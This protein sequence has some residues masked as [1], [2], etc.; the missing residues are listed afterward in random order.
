MTSCAGWCLLA[1]LASGV[2]AADWPTYQRDQG[3]SG[4]TPERLTLPLTEHWTYRAVQP[5]RPAWPAPA[6]RDIWHE[7]RELKPL[8]TYDRAFHTVVVGDSVFFASSGD[9]A[10]R[11]L[12]VAT[13]LERWTFFT[14]GPVRLAPVVA[15]GKAFVGSDDGAIYALAAADGALVWK[16]PVGPPTRRVA[17]NGRLISARPV[18]T[19]LVVEGDRL[20]GFAGLFP[21]EGVY[22]CV[23]GADDGRVWAE[24]SIAALSPQ[25]YLLASRDR[26]YVPTGRTT[27]A[28]FDKE[29]GKYLSSFGGTGG[30][31]ALLVDDLIYTRADREGNVGLSDAASRERIATFDGL[32]ILVAGGTAYLHTRSELAALDRVR[33]TA[34][35]RQHSAVSQRL[36]GIEEQLKG[37]PAADTR[38][39][40]EE[41]RAEAK[42]EARRLQEAMAACFTWRAPCDAPYH[43]ILA[44]D[45]LY[46]GGE[47]CVRAY[48]RADGKLRWTGRVSG[49]AYGLSVAQGR[50]FVSTDQGTI[51]C[52]GQGAPAGSSNEVSASTTAAAGAF[53][54]DDQA[55]GFAAAAARIAAQTGVRQ[56]Y[57]LV[58]GNGT[59]WLA[60][61][62]ARRTDLHIVGLEDNPRQV[63]AARSALSAAGLYGS[64][65]VVHEGSV[66]RPPYGA[67][68]FNLIVSERA[69]RT[70]AVPAPAEEVF[71][72]LR[73]EGGVA[74][75]GQ[76]D[77]FS[78]PGSPARFDSWWEAAQLT[79]T[80]VVQRA[81]R[82]LQVRRGPVPGGGEWTQLY[83]NPS[84]TASN[85]DRVQGPLAVQW[86]GEPGPRRIVDRHHRP[87][88]SLVKAGRLFVPGDDI[89]F[90]VDAYN[91][92]PLW[93]LEIPK[94]RRVGALKDSGQML[95]TDR[96][97]HV[98]TQ[99]ECWLV[100]VER[101]KRSGTLK[102]PQPIAGQSHDWGYLNQWNDRVYGTGQ[103][104]GASFT[105]LHKDTINTLEGDFRPVIV[106]RYVFSLGYDGHPHWLYR[107]GALMNNA[108]AIGDGRIYLLESRAPAV[109]ND[110]DGRVG[111]REF[112]AGE[113]YLVAL[114][115][116]R[117]GNVYERPV[118][119]PFEHI[120]FLN[121]A[122]N[123]VLIS[124]SFN[125]GNRVRY[126]LF[127]FH[128]DSG[129][130]KWQ[131]DYLAMD[132]RGDEPSPTDGTHGEQ[133]QHPVIL[134]DR[135]YSRPYDFDLHT[136]LKG[137]KTI[138]RGGHGCGGWTASAHYLYGRGGN[139][140]RYDL[141]LDSTQ[142]EPLTQ[143]SRPGCWLNVIPAGGLV[144]VPES[145]SGCTCSYPLQTSL[146]FVP[147]E[148][149]QPAEGDSRR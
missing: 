125:T 38:A 136:G 114:D 12:D 31:Y 69:L 78:E 116:E 95:V 91:G 85:D 113:T 96:F 50:L 138:Y 63:A 82:W 102:A 10:V 27:P 73:P 9:D 51:H 36:K 129:K 89:V 7:L 44:G 134:G 52:F 122:H 17:G 115:L 117:A 86:F 121:Y 54:A 107:N 64:R 23:L 65:V 141:S 57:C 126:G 19:G 109:V 146:A 21:E 119:L 123:T 90:A 28:I 56:G 110:P 3:R 49:R 20:Y 35:G 8:V 45:T 24:E 4:V 111:L 101:G 92:T 70:G 59:G 33:H 66:A 105:Q 55:E 42:T 112:C 118:Q 46:A 26:L 61:E 137:A 131:T 103:A 32:Q 68:L 1:H 72:L 47:D 124:G 97:L 99:D 14:E 140:R 139:P 71:R 77:A 132:I 106:S 60:H 76:L 148:V 25:G 142:G 84:H 48:D 39:Q 83:A 87:M 108:I 104:R 145:S 34:L 53:T 79:E 6:P 62:L 130:P 22:R 16:R 58:L 67:Y 5:P 143:A 147:R 135:I 37:R 13:G 41:Q 81:E 98:V 100:E 149:A 40:L 29:S 11:A 74:C 43:L 30:S 94:M 133:W 88:S 93:E 144:L 75:F 15:Q 2:Q 80:A 128:A 127:A 18:R 120:L